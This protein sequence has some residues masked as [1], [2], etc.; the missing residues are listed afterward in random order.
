VLLTPEKERVLQLL[1]ERIDYDGSVNQLDITWRL[2][3]FGQLAKEI[4]P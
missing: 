1:I 4:G 3:G 2:A